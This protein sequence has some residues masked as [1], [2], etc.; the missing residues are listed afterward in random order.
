MAA[1]LSLIALL[2]SPIGSRKFTR[3]AAEAID[4]TPAR[5]HRRPNL[6][7]RTGLPLASLFSYRQSGLMILL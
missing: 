5:I 3:L 2:W 6:R 1:A 7:R 4:C